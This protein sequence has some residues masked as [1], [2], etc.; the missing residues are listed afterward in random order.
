MLTSFSITFLYFGFVRG[1]K[2]NEL[3]K[4]AIYG[5]GQKQIAINPQEA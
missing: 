5:Q 4:R 2:S 3:N 1:W